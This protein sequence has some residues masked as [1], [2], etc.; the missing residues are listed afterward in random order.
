[1]LK[2]QLI[3]DAEKERPVESEQVYVSLNAEPT[4]RREAV[5]DV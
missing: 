4:T 5:G 2:G 1:V 3:E